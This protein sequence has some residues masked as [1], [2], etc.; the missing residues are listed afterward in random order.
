MLIVAG[1]ALTWHRISP[2]LN[3]LLLLLVLFVTWQVVARSGSIPL[4]RG[5]LLTFCALVGLLAGLISGQHTP[6]RFE[7]GE[8]DVICRRGALL[9]FTWAVVVII[10]ITLWT[11]PGL[12]APAWA[13]VL[14]PT[15]AFLTSAF[16]IS[17]LVIFVRA[18]ALRRD[19]FAQIEREQQVQ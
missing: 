16:T 18:S 8:N 14:S 17:T 5:F 13:A 6:M 9:I 7:P 4:D 15:L 10:S 12:R 19:Q 3:S 11:I 2:F 1:R